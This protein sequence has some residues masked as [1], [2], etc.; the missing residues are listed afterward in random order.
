MQAINAMLKKA[1]S[2][3]LDSDEE[4]EGEKP[5]KEDDDASQVDEQDAAST[6]GREDEYI[7]EDKYTEV[8]IEPMSKRNDRG[9]TSEHEGEDDRK[10][11][12]SDR[13]NST[14]KSKR[15]WTKDKPDSKKVKTKKK[16]F[17]YESKTERKTTKLHQKAKNAKA[18]QAR[19]DRE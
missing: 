12:N 15:V 16:K 9:D 18:A 14:D 1:E 11:S 3:A 13:A 2:G 19:R 7:D 17:R 8:T 10:A 5:S 6:S 4:P